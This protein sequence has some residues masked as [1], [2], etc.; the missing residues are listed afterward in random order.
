MQV[1]GMYVRDTLGNLRCLC[2]PQSI[3]TFQLSSP[4]YHII[5]SA[6]GGRVHVLRGTGR[7]WE[8]RSGALGPQALRC[9]C[10]RACVY[11]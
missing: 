4:S 2:K 11:V 9:A 1:E 7:K 6:G 5:V 8:G 3:M 10:V